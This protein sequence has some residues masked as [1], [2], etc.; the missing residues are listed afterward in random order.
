[1]EYFRNKYY[2]ELAKHMQTNTTAGL[3]IP[4]MPPVVAE[5]APAP[6]I[7]AVPEIPV[8]LDDFEKINI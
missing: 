8:D 2:A 7:P 4:T 1:L 6:P 3:V 5:P